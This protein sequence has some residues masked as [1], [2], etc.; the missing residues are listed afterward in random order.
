MK[1]IPLFAALLLSLTAMSQS[2]RVMTYNIRYASPNDGANGWENRRDLLASQLQF[3]QPT[4]VG[5]QEALRS[6]ID[7]LQQRLP[8]YRWVG[9]GRDDGRDAGEFSPIFYDASQVDLLESQ[10][11]WLS[12]TPEVPSRGWD[13]ALPRVVTWAKFRTK[14]GKRAFYHVN[15]HYDHRGPQARANSSRLVLQKI[16][17]IAG[18][19][20][21]LVTGDFNAT[22]AD[23]PIRVLTDEAN[24]DRL[25]DARAISSTPHYGPAG[26][27]NGFK[28]KETGA[29]IDFIFTKNGVTVER[30]AVLSQTWEGRFASD[31]HPVYA[32]VTLPR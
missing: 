28:E 12:E 31:H 32:E 14:K 11:F 7:D 27:F 15:T 13:A 17:E 2:L 29:A 16:K 8:A 25:T 5:M 10:T 18:Q 9:K 24:P 26:T 20:P 19:V 30:H 21:V 4:V 6:Q 3:H 22:T 1:T 23:E